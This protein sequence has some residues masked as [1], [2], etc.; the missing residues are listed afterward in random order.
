MAPTVLVRRTDLDTAFPPEKQ[1]QDMSEPTD[2]SGKRQ[3]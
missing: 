3:S 1:E 2:D